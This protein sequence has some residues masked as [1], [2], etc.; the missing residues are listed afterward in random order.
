MIGYVY[1][2]SH[3]M[4]FNKFVIYDI[5]N[6]LT[7]NLHIF[8]RRK[9]CNMIKVILWDIDG[10]LLDFGQAE[11]YAMKKCFAVLDMGVCT[12]EMVARY[13]AINTKYWERLERNEITKQE[14]LIGRFCEFF[15]KEGLPVE[16]AVPFNEEYQ[17]RLGD[18]VFF[19]DNAAM[20]VKELKERGIIQCA[21]TNGTLAAQ[22]RKLAASGLDR[23]LDNAF[24]SDEIG[25]EKPNI[26]F[27]EQVFRAISRA[28]NFKKN[29]IMI[30]G[31]SLTSDMQGGN[32]AGIVCCWYNPAGNINTKGLQIDYEIKNLN[33]LKEI[34]FTN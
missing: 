25:I 10:T 14:V 13:A 31:D 17:I 18:K 12:D 20:L 5:L 19:N 29:E 32:N 1:I 4:Q 28:G 33:K 26:E 6:K 11:N 27:F 15:E 8:E 7:L 16:K 30:V 24:I 2:V 3:F 21:V 34:L 9:T 23:I 22:K